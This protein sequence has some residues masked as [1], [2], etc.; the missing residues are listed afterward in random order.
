MKLIA[1]DLDGT[2]LS[3]N[4]MISKENAEAIRKCQEEGHVVA[5][6][7]G[8]SIVDIER[9]LQEVNLQCP[10]IAENG[11]VIY[12]DKTMLKRYA[13][14]NEHALDIVEYLEEQGMY[15]Q[16]YT[17]KGVY[18]PKYGE[19]NI[20]KEME[21]IRNLDINISEEE[22]ENIAALYLEHTAFHSIE[23]CKSIINKELY[24][25][26][27]LP[28]SYDQ[29]KLKRLKEKFQHNSELIISASYWHNL[30]INHCDAQKGNGLYTLAEYF[31]IPFENT[32][33]IGD[34]LNDVSM[35]QKANVSIAMGNAV[36]ELKAMCHYETLTN[37]EH[38]V[39]HA[40]Y[41]Y[42]IA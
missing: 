40:L 2:L 38:G 26:K 33:A 23:S 34:G 35:M 36:N 14:Q 20:R 11:A 37:E 13:I 17:D 39:A 7:T 9:L 6:C 4:K 32:V 15:Y 16:L 12:K 10:I 31:N 41:H 25:H 24:V 28:F 21:V 3:K 1:I 5:I 18:V 27:F 22:V 30:E 42:V 29:Q 8:R 19:E